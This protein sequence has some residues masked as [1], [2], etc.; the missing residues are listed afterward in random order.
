MRELVHVVLWLQE[1]H[2]RAPRLFYLMC[3]GV[4]LS[5]FGLAAM[6]AETVGR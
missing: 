1:F 5:I 6:I 4:G 2:R 3:A